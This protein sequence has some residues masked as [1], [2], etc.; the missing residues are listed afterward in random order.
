MSIDK[1]GR[2][3]LILCA[4]VVFS[5]SLC[6]LRLCVEPVLAIFNVRFQHGDSENAE[7]QRLFRSP[8]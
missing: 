3:F 6:P 4:S 7:T 8:F 5:V 2:L 1:L